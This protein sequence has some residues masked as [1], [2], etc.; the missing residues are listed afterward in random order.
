MN[1]YSF[2]TLQLL[3]DSVREWERE[4]NERNLFDTSKAGNS[5][6]TPR[7]IK[8]YTIE[9]NFDDIQDDE[10]RKCIE[11]LPTAFKLPPEAVKRV[12]VVAGKLLN[13]SE[14]YRALL[15]DLEAESKD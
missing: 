3:K 1:R 4:W 15:R 10:E 11:S 14:G 9:V 13:Q 2:D 12:R 8:I 5:T 6:G 7:Q